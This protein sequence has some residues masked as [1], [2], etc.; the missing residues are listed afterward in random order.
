M[1]GPHGQ[2]DGARLELLAADDDGV[3]AAG[4]VGQPHLVA[5][6]VTKRA[7]KRSA[8]SRMRVMSSG[9][10]IPSAKPG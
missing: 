8:W 4:L 3:D 2:H 10:M 5:W 6:S 9:P 7:P 1:L